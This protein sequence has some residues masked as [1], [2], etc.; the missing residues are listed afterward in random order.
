MGFETVITRLQMQT[1]LVVS[2]FVY[3]RDRFQRPYGWGVAEYAAP[4]T[5]FGADFVA[6][7]YR[8]P[9][10]ISKAR[11]FA[12]LRALLPQASAEEIAALLG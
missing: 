2:D 1:Y 6:S 7:A 11:M 9:P 5:L 3:E 4:E 12:H 10:E 8:T